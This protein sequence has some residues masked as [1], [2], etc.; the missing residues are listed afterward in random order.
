[1]EEW[2]RTGEAARRL[3]TSTTTVRAM[4]ARGELEH[5]RTPG[6]TRASWRVSGRSVDRWLA[7]YGRVSD[8]LDR[9][10]RTGEHGKATGARRPD[11]IEQEL[12]RTRSAR[13]ALS[14]EVATLRGVALQLR[15]RNEAIADAEAHQAKAG[16][17]LAQAFEE[18][19][20][21]ADQLRRGLAAQDDALGQFLV[22]GA[23]ALGAQTP[24]A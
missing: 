6:G 15:A 13:D 3:G 23:D 24:T 9:G 1:M 16:R 18:Q 2:L 8:R 21:A 7:A 5:T 10:K 22:P 19:A 4:A 12:R 14:G 11:D 20:A 17:L